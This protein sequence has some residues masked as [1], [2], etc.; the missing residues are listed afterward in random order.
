MEQLFTF[1]LKA[2]ISIALFYLLY[3]L[4]LRKETYYVANRYFLL[5]ALILSAIL[6]L[7]PYQ[8]SVIVEVGQNPNVFESLNNTF[9][10]IQPTISASDVSNFSLGL[11]EIITIIYLTGVS[12]FLLR[13]LIQS[14]ILIGLMI[15][16]K[17]KSLNG[18]RIVENEKYGLPFSFFNIVFIN[19]KFHTQ[20]DLPDILA[21]EKVHIRE[22]HWVDLIIIEL[23]TVIFWFNPFIWFFERSIKQNHEYL[24]DSAVIS[25]GN[26]VAKY[27]ALLVNQLMGMQIIG[28]TNS[29]NFALNT[30]R[31]KMM[32]K[33]K[34][35]KIRAFKLAWALPAIAILLVAFAEPNYK[36]KPTDVD[37][38]I[39]LL[40]KKKASKTTVI[41]NVETIPET[42]DTINGTMNQ[43]T[44][45]TVDSIPK[46]VFVYKLIIKSQVSSQILN[47]DIEIKNMTTEKTKRIKNLK[48]P[49]E[50]ILEN[51]NY[52]INVYKT[53]GS[54][55]LV[56]GIFLNEG[57]SAVAYADTATLYI[58]N[59]VIGY[60][61]ARDGLE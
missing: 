55:N 45:Q 52:K 10:T 20:E 25:N 24:A 50:K 22:N 57:T 59:H 2:S 47:F 28:I 15:K 13:L 53:S 3:W 4:F 40:P 6:P 48:T 27:Q 60:I 5:L 30:N 23:L 14:A 46:K 12:I 31:L 44:T 11:V 56:S 39:N 17:I 32:T 41:E 34:T 29:L 49:Y 8:Y 21:H 18:I 38:T 19:P 58:L 26:Q 36:I 42:S 16:Y 9:K 54:G 61:G 43:S 35:P 33:K 7:I 51:E 1:L 37:S